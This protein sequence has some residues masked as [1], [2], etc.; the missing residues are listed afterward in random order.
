MVPKAANCCWCCWPLVAVAV[1]MEAGESPLVAALW[2]AAAT[3]AAVSMGSILTRQES[4]CC[5]CRETRWA[6]AAAAGPPRW[7]RNIREE[8]TPKSGLG[9]AAALEWPFLTVVMVAGASSTFSTRAARWRDSEADVDR[10][11]RGAAELADQARRP[12]PGKQRV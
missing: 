7:A 9:R 2:A 3:D 10:L 12:P 6:A 1:R 5:C 11:R 8:G 4:C